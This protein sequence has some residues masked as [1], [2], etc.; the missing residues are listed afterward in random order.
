ML[1]R[2]EKDEILGKAGV[3]KLTEKEK[4][5][6]IEDDECSAESVFSAAKLP[7]KFHMETLSSC[8]VA[9][10]IDMTPGQGDF[11]KACVEM[12]TPALCFGFTEKHN[13]CLE[14]RL[15]QWAVA[16]M[17]TEGSSLR[18]KNAQSSLANA[19]K[20][21]Q[22]G[23]SAGED[24][25]DPMP[26]TKKPKTEDG[27]NPKPKKEPKRKAKI[28][29]EEDEESSDSAASGKKAK[30]KSRKRRR[31]RAPRPARSH[32]RELQKGTAASGLTDRAS[33]FC[34]LLG[35]TSKTYLETLR[36]V[37]LL[38]LRSWVIS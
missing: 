8:C 21:S 33:R 30:T 16:Q 31:R 1:N 23:A 36:M 5:T 4:I 2:S 37:L 10:A 25:E 20:P 28:K 19:K 29:K 18:R 35:L 22:A 24:P 11:L 9:A 14:E 7:V 3:L 13:K 6:V 32:G 34:F 26:S 15:T 27:E 12:R 38:S 17:A